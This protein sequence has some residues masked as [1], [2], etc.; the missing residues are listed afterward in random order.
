MEH[1]NSFKH[2]CSFMEA[3]PSKKKLGRLQQQGS[4]KSLTV[5][6]HDLVRP[7]LSVE[8]RNFFDICFKRE[9]AYYLVKFS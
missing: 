7:K 2:G 3:T 1:G 4:R 9:G 6:E 5:R 8:R